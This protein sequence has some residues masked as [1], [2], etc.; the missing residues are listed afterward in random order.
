MRPCTAAPSKTCRL[1]RGPQDHTRSIGPAHTP[2]FATVRQLKLFELV[3]SQPLALSCGFREYGVGSFVKGKILGYGWPMWPTEGAMPIDH[4]HAVRR[5]LRGSRITQ[6]VLQD[7][8]TIFLFFSG[9]RQGL[10]RSPGTKTSQ[11]IPALEARG[12][13]EYSAP[14]DIVEYS[15]FYTL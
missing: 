15:L 5:R 9:L 3:Y 13:R 10:P 6:S 4:D 1:F 11:I 12:L 7:T 2:T 14:R 8:T